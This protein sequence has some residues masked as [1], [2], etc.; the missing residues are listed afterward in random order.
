M[1]GQFLV[2]PTPANPV[3]EHGTKEPAFVSLLSPSPPAH[4]TAF[5]SIMQASAH[6]CPLHAPTAPPGG[7]LT[8]S[9]SVTHPR[10]LALAV[11]K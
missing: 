8:S 6:S 5:L 4:P 3:S 10:G 2:P 1:E 9:L 7:L 11:T